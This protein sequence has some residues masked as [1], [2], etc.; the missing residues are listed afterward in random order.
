MTDMT[1]D[2][3]LGAGYY[4][5]SADILT[6]QDWKLLGLSTPLIVVLL[7]VAGTYLL[8][9]SA[10]VFVLTK[11]KNNERFAWRGLNLMTV[12]QMLYR[13]R[14]NVKILTLIGSSP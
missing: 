6:S 5:A 10:T 14:G 9:H 2:L 13:I 11:M 3:R 12:S 7:V 1:N 4:L 8:F